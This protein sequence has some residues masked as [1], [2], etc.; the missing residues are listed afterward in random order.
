MRILPKA[1]VPMQQRGACNVQDKM[2]NR[3]NEKG[4][5]WRETVIWYFPHFMFHVFINSTLEKVDN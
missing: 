3:L 4:N 2:G 1:Q 5:I